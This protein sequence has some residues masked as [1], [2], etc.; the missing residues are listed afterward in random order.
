VLGFA[1]PFTGISKAS[2]TYAKRWAKTISLI[3]KPACFDFSSSNFN[4]Q[5]HILSTGGVALLAIDTRVFKIFSSVV[6]KVGK[7]T[8]K[9]LAILS[10][11]LQQ[12]WI[13]EKQEEQSFNLFFP[14]HYITLQR[15]EPGQ[16]DLHYSTLL[17]ARKSLDP[18]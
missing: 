9:F 4:L 3:Q 1:V 2:A 14:F 16:L 7:K 8:S 5:S 15:A 13:K 12:P 17:S 6:L 18:I 11:L 10:H